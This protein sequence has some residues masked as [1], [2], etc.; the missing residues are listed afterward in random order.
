VQQLIG[1]TKS[2]VR[3]VCRF[4]YNRTNRCVIWNRINL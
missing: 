4:S 1:M 3:V 2:A